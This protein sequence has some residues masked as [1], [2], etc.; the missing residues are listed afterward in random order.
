MNWRRIITQKF[1]HRSES[2]KPHAR[3]P[4]FRVW[5]QEE[6]PPENLALKARNSTLRGHTQG[7]LCM[8]R[9]TVIKLTKNKDK[10]KIL[11][12]AREKQ[13]ITYRGIPIR[14]SGDFS[15]ETAG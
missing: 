8:L 1:S 12:A 13:L 15:A 11:K 9:H 6:K 2:S 5:K 14:L 4:S 7:L 3:L 10:E